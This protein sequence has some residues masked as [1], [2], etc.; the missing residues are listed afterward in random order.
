MTRFREVLATGTP[1]ARTIIPGAGDVDT[2]KDG[3]YTRAEIERYLME[4]SDA[5]RTLL[6]DVLARGLS[7][8]EKA[9]LQA[10]VT[11]GGDLDAALDGVTGATDAWK[12]EVRALLDNYNTGNIRVAMNGGSIDSGGDG[13]R[14]WYA[15][16]HDRNGAISVTVAE[17]ASV[18]GGAAG[19][20]VANAG[21]GLRIAKKY[22]TPAAQDENENLK[23]D[24][25][26]TLADY[27]NQVV[28]VD[29]TVTGGEDAAVHL[30][31]GGAAHRRAYR[32]AGRR[33][34]GPDDPRERPGPGDHL[35]RGPGEG[36]RRRAN[37]GGPDR[38]GWADGRRGPDEWRPTGRVAPSGATTR[39]PPW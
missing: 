38:R 14:A 29:G 10:L 3:S 11:D 22:L 6:R 27:L 18:T 31:G 19:V 21:A 12:D 8:A 17:G 26:V 35:D 13:I 4:D 34:L 5:R 9:V 25:L 30:A 28:R 1:P 24:D 39:R 37:G 36:W 7:A 16:Q 20:Y 23:P 32:P 2:D 33:L 15:R